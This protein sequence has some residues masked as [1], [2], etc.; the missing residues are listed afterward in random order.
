[1]E[2]VKD[3]VTKRLQSETSGSD[4]G[5]RRGERRGRWN[6]WVEMERLLYFS[7][8][9]GLPAGAPRSPPLHGAPGEVLGHGPL[10]H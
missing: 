4:G 6:V 10:T 1:M 3:V 7:S 5:G 9:I 2:E 8:V